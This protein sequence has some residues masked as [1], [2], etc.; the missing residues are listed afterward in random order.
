MHDFPS[1]ERY[2]QA[3]RMTHEALRL[4]TTS[5]AL[6]LSSS[7]TCSRLAREKSLRKIVEL[8][9]ISNAI[10]TSPSLFHTALCAIFYYISKQTT[11][12]TDS[13]ASF[14]TLTI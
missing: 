9:V 1:T 3:L 8:Q 12:S 10:H 14:A 5:R 11:I 13:D 7:P 4:S 2:L 6:S